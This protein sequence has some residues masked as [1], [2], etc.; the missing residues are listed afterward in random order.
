VWEGVLTMPVFGSID[1]RRAEQMMD[2]LLRA[3]VR[4]R[5]RYVI[6]DLTGVDTVDTSTADHIIKLIHSVQLVGSKGIVVGIRPEVARTVVS[7][8]VDLSSFITLAN[9]REGLL[10]CMRDRELAPG[11]A[12]DAPSAGQRWNRR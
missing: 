6:I 1:A 11:F 8:G 12:K 10:F 3:I 4:V 9:L 5:C 2:I 7:I